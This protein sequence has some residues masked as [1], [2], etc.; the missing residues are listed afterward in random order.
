MSLSEKQKQWIHKRDA[1]ECQFPDF[2]K[3]QLAKCGNER[4]LEVHHILCQRYAQGLLGMSEQEIDDPR[5]LILICKAH[6]DGVVHPDVY[7]ALDEYRQGNKNSFKEMQ[8]NRDRIVAEGDIYWNDTYDEA[9]KYVA[10]ERTDAWAV[11]G[12]KWPRKK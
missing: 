8:E 1:E 12:H 7:T 10:E 4:Q 5:N 9:L 6:H 11:R 2:E 3:G